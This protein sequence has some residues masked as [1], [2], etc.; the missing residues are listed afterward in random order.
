MIHQN[1]LPEGSRFGTPEN[2]EAISSLCGLERAMQCGKILE[3]IVTLCDSAMRLH[4][5]LG[6]ICGIIPKSEAVLCKENEQMKDIAVITRVGKP[7][8][9]CVIAI[10]HENGAPVAI[11]SR[12]MAQQECLKHY[13]STL[14]PGDVLPAIV[15]HLEGFGAFVDI[16][17]GISSLLS[18]DCLSVSR[19][20]HPSDRL[21]VGNHIHTVIKHID[22]ENNRIYVS[23]RELLGTWEE[24]ASNFEA[25]QT[26]VGI[27]RS[28]EPYGVFV[29][30]AP[31]LAGLAEIR[32]GSHDKQIAVVGSVVAVYIK[33]IIPE[34]MKIKLVLIDAYR[35]TPPA[36]QLKYYI[37]VT[38]TQHIARW[39][40]SPLCCA[41]VIETVYS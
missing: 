6:G 16:G 27:I 24:N 39:R 10:H 22:Y 31:N 25:G 5:D 7:T 32:E 30:L 8:C 34:R 14:V 4:V 13:M 36:Q 29:E 19:I 18:V 17:C 28:I 23:M 21:R 35:G 1:Y 40:Y 20:S 11:L 9:F 15:T 12:R 3:A 2:Q 37:D 41:R 33:S 26:V 38:R